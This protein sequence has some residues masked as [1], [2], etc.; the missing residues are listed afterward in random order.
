MSHSSWLRHIRVSP[1]SEVQQTMLQTTTSFKD[2]DSNCRTSTVEQLS[3]SEAEI[4][5]L[6]NTLQDE[7]VT[8][9]N[10]LERCVIATDWID[11]L[12][13]QK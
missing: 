9:R 6:V 13:F 11:E 5:R 2:Q 4:E 3:V 1:S 12:S 7:S 10:E 8:K